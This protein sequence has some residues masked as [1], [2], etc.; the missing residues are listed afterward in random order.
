MPEARRV[1]VITGASAGVGRAIA[2]RFADEGAAIALLGRQADRLD[3]A[4]REV[5][6]AGSEALAVSVDVSGR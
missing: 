2:R 3:A 1:V 5:L 6:D 4:V